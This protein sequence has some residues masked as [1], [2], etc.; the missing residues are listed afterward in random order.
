MHQLTKFSKLSPPIPCSGNLSSFKSS[1]CTHPFTKKC[2]FPYSLHFM[3]LLF[4]CSTTSPIFPSHF[5]YTKFL[6]DFGVSLCT[7]AHMPWIHLPQCRHKVEL[8]F[9]LKLQ[10]P[11]GSSLLLDVPSIVMA[12]SLVFPRL[13]F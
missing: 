10:T 3:T 4:F 9:T 11:H 12:I 5:L 13:T 1:T 8:A 2:E 6:E 7:L